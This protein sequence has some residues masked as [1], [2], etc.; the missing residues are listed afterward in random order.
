MSTARDLAF[1]VDR[2]LRAATDRECQR[3]TAGYFPSALENLGVG[4][5]VQH[6][7]ARECVRQLAGEPRSVVLAFARAVLAQRTL[8]GRPGSLPRTA[9]PPRCARAPFKAGDRNTRPRNGQLGQRRH[10]RL[11]RGRPGLARRPFE[12]RGRA[13][14]ESGARPL[15]EACC[16]GR[17][18]AVEHGR[19]RRQ[20]RRAPHPRALQIAGRRPRRHD[21]QGTILGAAL[22][23]NPRPGRSTSFSARA[24]GR[25]ACACEARG[26]EQA[27]DGSE[28][29]G[30]RTTAI[31]IPWRWRL[32]PCVPSF[33]VRA[34]KTK[35]SLIARTQSV[36]TA[37]AHR[38]PRPREGGWS[39][40]AEPSA[41]LPRSTD[42]RAPS[43]RFNS[44][45]F[46]GERGQAGMAALVPFRGA[47]VGTKCGAAPAAAAVT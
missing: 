12:R 2:L 15:V 34:R 23:R 38:A 21:R 19:A 40:G 29:C 43:S 25:T 14:L 10:L 17:H 4:A 9:R 8:E 37:G 18:S 46:D 44:H 36:T 22:A 11:L 16:A 39:T 45:R 7:L 47:P 33:D 20:G 6:R 1:E 32:R 41:R 30:R 42:S 27:E 13:P 26:H 5:P 28:D 3:F 24:R 31:L 35:S